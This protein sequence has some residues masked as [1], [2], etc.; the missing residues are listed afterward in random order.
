MNSIEG[1]M[2]HVGNVKKFIKNNIGCGDDRDKIKGAECGNV[3]PKC[4]EIHYCK[5]CE[6]LIKEAGCK[7]T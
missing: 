3:C 1:D 5:R 2:I 6:K 7:L 4:D